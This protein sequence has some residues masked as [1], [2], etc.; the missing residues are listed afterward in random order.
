MYIFTAPAKAY[1]V[2]F[3]YEGLDA[4]LKAGRGSEAVRMIGKTLEVSKWYA[5]R[6]QIKLYDT[7]IGEVLSNGTVA[8]MEAI[9]YHGSQATTWWVS[10]LLQDNKCGEFVYREKGQYAVAGK[11]YTRNV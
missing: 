7:I 6:I 4:F 9:N 2:P 1:E 10:K 8:V 5:G 11:A 3:T